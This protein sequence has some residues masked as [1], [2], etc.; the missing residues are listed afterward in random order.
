MSAGL[1]GSL[2][3]R[4][5]LPKHPSNPSTSPGN[6]PGTQLPSPDGFPELPLAPLRPLRSRRKAAGSRV[7]GEPV[8]S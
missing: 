3:R 6:F 7:T 2:C 4:H 5:W 1:R 8:T